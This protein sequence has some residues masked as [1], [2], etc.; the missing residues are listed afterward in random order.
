VINDGASL[1]SQLGRVVLLG[2]W[3][4]I[5]FGAAVKLFRWT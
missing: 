3:T 5:P 4:A 2:V 1:S